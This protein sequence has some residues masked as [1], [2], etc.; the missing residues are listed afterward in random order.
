M[1]VLTGEPKEVW[2]WRGRATSCHTAGNLRDSDLSPTRIRKDSSHCVSDMSQLGYNKDLGVWDSSLLPRVLWL[3]SPSFLLKHEGRALSGQ[4]LGFTYYVGSYH[5]KSW[6]SSKSGGESIRK[7]LSDH[8]T[9]IVSSFKDQTAEA[10][11][12]KLKTM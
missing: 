10:S 12:S 6:G 4:K 5:Q 8:L 11:V 1:F 9:K 7:P 2:S 3:S